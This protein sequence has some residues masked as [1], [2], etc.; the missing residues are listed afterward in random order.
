MATE[1]SV[2]SD[3][4]VKKYRVSHVFLV[5]D[6]EAKFDQNDKVD[7]PIFFR[8]KCPVSPRFQVSLVFKDGFIS[9]TI[10]F[11]R[12]K[13]AFCEV[14]VTGGSFSLHDVEWTFS[15]TASRD[16]MVSTDTSWFLLL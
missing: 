6:I 15:K 4:F 10:A 2:F 9:A 12:L 11:D 13:A 7:S 1:E 3:S 5:K 8:Q 14:C 16:K